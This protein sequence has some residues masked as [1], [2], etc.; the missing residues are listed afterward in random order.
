MRFECIMRAK[1]VKKQ[2]SL[3]DH[4]SMRKGRVVVLR[5]I[6][7]T[8]MVGVSKVPR[9]EDDTVKAVIL[10]LLHLGSDYIAMSIR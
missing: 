4:N 5:N 6:G 8:S 10:S 3:A 7:R 2:L 1:P 9:T